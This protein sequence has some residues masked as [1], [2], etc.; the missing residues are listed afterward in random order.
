MNYGLPS[1]RSPSV[2][3]IGPGAIELTRTPFGPHSILMCRV[4]ASSNKMKYYTN[5]PTRSFFLEISAL[6][7]IYHERR[8]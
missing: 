1:L 8:G 5:M 6:G 4:S 3:N 7:P 2:P